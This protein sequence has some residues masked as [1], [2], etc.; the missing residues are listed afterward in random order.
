MLEL[1]PN[2]G[3]DAVVCVFGIFFLPDM[4]GAVRKLWALVRPG[5][6][7]AV[8]TWGPRFFEPAT[9][10]FW[11]SIREVRPDL[12]RELLYTADLERVD[13]LDGG[14]HHSV[15]LVICAAAGPASS[16]S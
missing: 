6:N 7:L 3:F 5:G 12:Y 14:Y 2:G 10:A 4:P 11:D 13:D 1:E 8:T 16:S 15:C 9:T